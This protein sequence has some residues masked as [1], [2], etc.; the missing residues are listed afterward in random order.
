VDD[1]PARRKVGHAVAVARDRDVPVGEL[2]VEFV[3]GRV[4]AEPR[5]E[6]APGLDEILRKLAELWTMRD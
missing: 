1:V 6:V 4:A 3:G 5:I 2:L